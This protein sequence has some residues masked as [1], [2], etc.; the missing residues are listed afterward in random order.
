MR[1]FYRVLALVLIL[2]F[3]IGSAS[4]ASRASDVIA[5]YGTNISVTSSG[6][7]YV[8]FNI[9]GSDIMSVIG[10]TCIEIEKK[11]SGSWRVVETYTYATHPNLRTTNALYH[12]SS[13]TYSPMLSGYDYR[14]HVTFYASNGT[15]SDTRDCYTAIVQK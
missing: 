3:V 6:D 7:L 2:S 1:K 5:V 8:R 15:S 14:A 12:V 4:A 10:A 13:I 9:T 11:V